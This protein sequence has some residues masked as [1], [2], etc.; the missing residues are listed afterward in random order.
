MNSQSSQLLPRAMSSEPYR[1]QLAERELSECDLQNEVVHHLVSALRH[2]SSAS[3]VINPVFVDQ[4]ESALRVYLAT[5]PQTQT[6]APRRSTRG[7]LPV[8]KE[9][10]VKELMRSELS[11]K[12]SLKRLASECG[13][14]IRHFTRAFRLSTGSSPRR[15][16]AK[17]RIETARQLLMKPEL[18]LHD[19]AMSCGFADQSHFT[20]AF[21]AAEKMSPGM[22]RRLHVSPS[23]DIRSG[24]QK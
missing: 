14:S 19:I 21:S 8:W 15:Y 23:D 13:L 3:Q 10:R 6:G 5:C 2:A 20:R 16:L 11:S 24:F 9:R 4:V 22:W 17:L 7:K 12:L 1:V 18:S